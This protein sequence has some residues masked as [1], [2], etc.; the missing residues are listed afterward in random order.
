MKTS[1][2][3][4]FKTVFTLQAIDEECEVY[5]EKILKVTQSTTQGHI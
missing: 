5:P 2:S 4:Y 3:V 1:K